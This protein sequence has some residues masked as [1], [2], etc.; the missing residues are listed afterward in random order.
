MELIQ[1]MRTQHIPIF[2]MIKIINKYR[3]LLAIISKTNKNKDHYDK[4]L[5]ISKEQSDTI[6]MILDFKEYYATI[7]SEIFVLLLCNTQ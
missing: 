4:Y 1:L 6:L 3:I 2:L 7:K 5:N